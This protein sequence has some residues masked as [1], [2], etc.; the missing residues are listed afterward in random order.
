MC[1]VNSTVKSYISLLTF[2]L[3]FPEIS[4]LSL[5]LVLLSLKSPAIPWN[6]RLRLSPIPL[7]PF[8]TFSSSHSTQHP[9]SHHLLSSCYFSARVLS[10]DSQ[11]TS[12]TSPLLPPFLSLPLLNLGW[13][14]PILFIWFPVAVCYKAV[15]FCATGMQKERVSAGL[16]PAAARCRGW[17][18]LVGE[19]SCSFPKSNGS[20]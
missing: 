12:L 15:L 14:V 8:M 18:S 5:L 20:F 4:R 2:H 1:K 3:L 19:G 6:S 7:G 10:N 16:L 11:Y 13:L 9:D 17:K